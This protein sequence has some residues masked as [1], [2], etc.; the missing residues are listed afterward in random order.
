MA[1]IKKHPLYGLFFLGCV[2]FFIYAH[3]YYTTTPIFNSPDETANF[4]FITTVISDSQILFPHPFDYAQSANFVFPRSTYA[5]EVGILPTG[6]WGIILLFG[7]VGKFFGAASAL[8]ITPL[9]TIMAGWCFYQIV[10]KI[11]GKKVGLWS[12]LLYITHP[13]V[14][15]VASRGLSPNGSFVSLLIIGV[16]FLLSPSFFSRIPDIYKK[17]FGSICVCL[18]LWIRPNEAIWVGTVLL[19]LCVLY[20]RRIQKSTMVA[21]I[22]TGLSCVGLYFWLNTYL[23]G[24]MQANYITSSSVVL[25]SWYDIIFPF[26]VHP[27]YVIHVFWDYFFGLFWWYT[28]P[29]GISMCLLVFFKK[30]QEVCK[31]YTHVRNYIIITS[32]VS[33]F[34]LVYYGSY[35]SL[36][37]TEPSVG[38]SFTRYFLPI[39]ILLIPLVVCFWSKIVEAVSVRFRVFMHILLFCIYITT[40]IHL[41]Y[42]GKDGLLAVS[43]NIQHAAYVREDV[44]SYLEKNA[45]ILTSHEDKFFWPTFQVMQNIFDPDIVAAAG[46]L[47]NRGFPVY[48]FGG[49]PET[50]VYNKVQEHYVSARIEPRLVKK[51]S[52]HALY[53][54][55]TY[56]Q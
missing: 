21:A 9:L 12:L 6:F 22:V 16:C 14:W 53:K 51:Y 20:W 8:Y 31:N 46:A 25:A 26:G 1:G 34:L 4:I 45:V 47:Y 18:G 44:S 35:A 32:V 33:I 54:F 30:Q 10:V 3:F 49:M 7:L 50:A 39:Y 5:T 41:V 11:F 38:V 56:E 2:F 15:Y 43:E 19:L 42:N 29:A 23:F 13:V 27:R 36:A 40:S 52:P 24:S 37:Q 28:V 48:Y 55:Y 17:I